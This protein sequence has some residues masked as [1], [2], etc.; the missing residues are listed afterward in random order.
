MFMEHLSSFS[1]TRSRGKKLN[2]NTNPW[3]SL[4]CWNSCS[5]QD[6]KH[7]HT[8]WYTPWFNF[9][10]S[11][12][13]SNRAEVLGE[14]P[15]RHPTWVIITIYFSLRSASRRCPKRQKQSTTQTKCLPICFME[16]QL[17]YTQLNNSVDVS[18]NFHLQSHF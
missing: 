11:V 9:L 16:V 4:T 10:E 8:L 6:H 3:Q 5:S 14:N 17:L 1:D 18:P 7:H 13:E 2:T 15:G 12:V